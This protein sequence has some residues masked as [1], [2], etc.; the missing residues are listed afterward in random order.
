[1]VMKTDAIRSKNSPRRGIRMSPNV[2]L[3]LLLLTV[4]QIRITS[5]QDVPSVDLIR[6]FSTTGMVADFTQDIV[7][8]EF[9]YISGNTS[10]TFAGQTN[11]GSSD[12]FVIKYNPSGELLW[13]N[14]F[15]TNQTETG[16]GIASDESGVYITGNTTGTFPG[17]VPFGSTDVYIR[18]LNTSGNEVWTRQL[19]TAGVD[20]IADG[21]A[22][23]ASAVYIAGTTL[24]SF[25]GYTNPDVSPAKRDVYI[26]K[27]SLEGDQLWIKQLE[28]PGED[29]C[30]GL[31]LDPTGIYLCGYRE[32]TDVF[33]SKYNLDGNI[34]WSQSFGT[35]GNDV[36]NEISGDETGI[37]VSGN[38]NGTFPGQSYAGGLNDAF[39]VK[40]DFLGNQL[41]LSEF[42]TIKN[43]NGAGISINSS[44]VYIC[45]YTDD[46]FPGQTN[47]GGND[48][49]VA[50]YD[51][52]GNQLWITM[53]GS[54]RVSSTPH[55]YAYNISLSSS[56]A[57][58][59]GTTAGLFPGQANYGGQDG[60]LI[61]LTVNLPPLAN[62]G[63][64]QLKIITETVQLD[65]SLSS[66]PDGD[67]ITYLWS[68]VDKPSESVAELCNATAVDP[69]FIADV[70][71]NY[72]IQ[73]V[74]ND[75]TVDSDP[76]QVTITVLTPQQA[77]Q[78]LI[79]D[80]EELVTAGVLNHGQGNALIVKLQAAIQK[81]DQGNYNAA[82]NNLNAFI[83]QVNAFRNSG[84]LTDE[85]ANA[86]IGAAERIIDVLEVLLAK[87]GLAIGPED[88]EITSELL[89]WNYPNPFRSSTVIS[90]SLLSDLWV[91]LK[92]YDTN[93]KEI[94]VLV[95]GLQAKGIHKVHF[96]AI[97]LP[98]GIYYYRMQAGS[99]SS[100]RKI[101]L[102]K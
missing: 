17:Q 41:W 61:K 43:D 71:G 8:G 51:R 59:T 9:I 1:M 74:T 84:I 65:G 16:P 76:C 5:G 58:I 2:F 77:T 68:I 34:V 22:L 32:N 67:D 44:G 47:T 13:V 79:A 73:L 52:S 89:T 96:E 26:A 50:K 102:L 12:A 70:A 80:V 10:G 94:S 4:C 88:N 63:E 91:V 29:Y 62:C 15:G 60:F 97:G 28:S 46:A 39:V 82:I 85:Q 3:V 6:Q 27:Y 56:E 24:G 90:Y 31:Y 37:Y 36:A 87:R 49:F 78:D 72:M 101:I 33:I 20:R 92:V 93:G 54:G 81:M 11:Y 75:G 14:E 35:S 66:D 69:S 21:I 86:L 18:K 25:P 7:A 45:G 42:G 98:G 30:N 83:N 99:T 53:N 95:D 55:D 64:D 57:F 48:I 19:G 23:D 100:I 38:T 40:Y